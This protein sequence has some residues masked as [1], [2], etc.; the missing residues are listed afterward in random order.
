MTDVT[1]IELRAPYLVFI[2]DTDVPSFAKTG[3][4]IVQWRRQ[5]VAG[6]LRFAGNSLDLGVPDMDIQ[7]AVAAGVKSILIGVAPIGGS[8]GPRWIS[9]LAEAA[10]AGLDVVNGLHLRLEDFPEIVAAAQASGA[11][12]VNV[13]VP[14]PGLPIGSGNKRSGRRLLMVGTDCAVGKKYSAL[15]LAAAMSGAGI[16][17][18]FRAT[19]QTGI[20]IAGNGMPIDAVVADFIAGAAEVLTP[21]NDPQHWDVIEGQGSLF[22][23]AYAG[24]SLGLLHGSQPDAIVVCHAADRRNIIGSPQARIP[25][26]AECI[27]LNLRCGRI[28]SADIQCVGVCVNTT[29][30]A[31]SER[32]PYLA[33]LSTELG[34]P[35]VDPMTDGCEPIV[36]HI[37]RCF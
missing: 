30:L 2:G 12:L 27:D 25:T 15:A 35:C 19:G 31:A 3:F 21:D 8:V 24:V 14:P 5:Q 16:N 4:G 1:Q 6:Q 13:R 7:Q 10:A 37:R 36:A 28:T 32:E 29:G 34:L 17:A 20:M 23:P 9:V 33:A 11:A 22:S 18:S 26:I